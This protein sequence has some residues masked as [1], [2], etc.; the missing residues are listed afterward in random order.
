MENQLPVI[1]PETPERMEPSTVFATPQTGPLPINVPNT[2]KIIPQSPGLPVNP[3][4]KPFAQS[5]LMSMFDAA[6][7]SEKKY[8]KKYLKYKMKYLNLAKSLK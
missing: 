8:Y 7:D 5:N 4:E 6:E 3:D 1:P 2:N